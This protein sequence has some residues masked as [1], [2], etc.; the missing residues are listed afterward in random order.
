L[1]DKMRIR[2]I[3]IISV[4]LFSCTR[5]ELIVP[6]DVLPAKELTSILTDIHLA[7]SMLNNKSK[8]DSINFTVNDYLPVVL[9]EH[10]TDKETFLRSL[11]FYS[12]NTEKIQEIYDSVITSLN[13]IQGEMEK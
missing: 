11:K 2:I 3:I 5:K 6:E 4:V 13:R 7:Q 9:K 1:K 10:H 8:S 12:D